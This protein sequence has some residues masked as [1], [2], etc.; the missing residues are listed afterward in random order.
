MAW[1]YNVA[2]LLVLAV[3][4]PWLL[5]QAWRHGKYTEGWSQKFLG[6]VPQREGHRPCIWLHAVSVGEV[7]LLQTLLA[8]LERDYPEWD[9]VISTTTRT[10]YALA[11]K[12]YSPRMVFYAPLD[13]SW[14]VRQA[15]ARMQPRLLI[16]AELELWPNFVQAVKAAGAKV[17]VMNGRLSDNS[18]RRYSQFAWLVRPLF[19]QLDLVAAQTAEYADRFRQLG[20]PAAKVH[21]TGSLK[22]DGAVSDRENAHTQRLRLLA[23]IAPSDLLFLAGSTQEPE[24]QLALATW[25]ALSPSHPQLKLI[26]VPRHPERFE[27]VAHLLQASGVAWQRRSELHERNPAQPW[28]VLLVDAVGEL[29]AWWGTAQ[30][31]FVGGSLGNRGGQ[32]MIEPAAYGAAICFGPNTW[33][34]RDVV[35]RFLA[36]EAAQVIRDGHELT[37]FVTRCLTDASFAKTLGENAAHLVRSQQG[38]AETTLALLKPLLV[39]PAPEQLVRL[40]PVNQITQPLARRA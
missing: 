13:F 17:A 14:A 31:A 34:F 16:L 15:V 19:S 30:V 26:L 33:N 28:Q 3:A 23:G 1:L 12:R 27:P 9:I 24:E 37:A 36:A 20:T 32:N 22:F 40:P 39:E 38:A 2:Y 35:A 29:G 6:W 7:N 10:G 11:K 5:W 25:Q 21:V 4:W 8:R 18:F